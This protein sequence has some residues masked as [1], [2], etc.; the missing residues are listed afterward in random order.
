MTPRFARERGKLRLWETLRWA[1]ASALFVL[2]AWVGAARAE[3][4]REDQARDA[5]LRV[6]VVRA[7]RDWNSPWKLLPT[8][9]VVGTAFLIDGDRLVTNAH[10]VRDAQQVTVKKGDGSAPAIATVEAVDEDCD[11]AL[12]RVPSKS[13][14]RG[15]HPL[16]VGQLPAI[17][18]SVVT[19]GYPI[20]GSELSTTSGVVSRIDNHPYREALAQ[21]LVVQTDAAINPGNSGGPVVQRGAVIGV[22]F[23][24]I[25]TAQN[26]GY[27]IP[28]PVLR[29]FLDDLAN[30]HYE[31]FPDL[32]IRYFS[33]NSPAL[34]R[35]RRLPDDRSGVVVMD[36]AASSDLARVLKPG[37]VLTAVEGQR[38]ADDGTC[39]LGSVRVPFTHL[40]DMKSLG[41]PARF[42]VWRDGK[43]IE[44]EWKTSRFA[45]FERLR[46]GNV[47]RY[48]VYAG[49]LF[50]PATF[51]YVAALHPTGNR[52][53]AIVHEVGF[54]PWVQ[55]VAPDEETVL[56]AHVFG[57]VVNAGVDAAVPYVVRALNAQPVRSLADLARM[58]EEGHPP[59][60]VFELGPSH[61]MEAIDREK[62]RAARDA[63]LT[64]YG[65][66][67][68][69]SL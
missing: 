2:I 21:H 48:L 10:V 8:E 62:A 40:V 64:T 22:S 45:M 23:Q 49:L 4:H 58:L 35:E 39:S 46:R 60:D 3:D 61:Q 53:A 50:V 37:D 1:G 20:G 31:G 13:F 68:D 5:V 26:I 24:V 52:R 6:E 43:P 14:L 41:Q 33:L 36:V 51:E 44:V 17:G 29:H 30:G 63:I 54:R 69:K 25:A 55:A 67:N 15:V 9:S 11:L 42:G 32:P 27:V 18:S 57:H 56:L 38:I 7:P 47:P 19:Y 12:L 59:Y 65:I 28:A 34:R 66:P 16:K